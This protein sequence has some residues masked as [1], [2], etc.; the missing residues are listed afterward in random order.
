MAYINSQKVATRDECGLV[1]IGNHLDISNDGELTI[2]LRSIIEEGVWQPKLI[3][4]PEGGAIT[5]KILYANYSKIGSLV[6]AAFDLQVVQME[7]GKGKTSSHV[8]IEG[9]PLMSVS[10][11]GYCGSVNI[12]YFNN[13]NS[14]VCALSGS[15]RPE[16]YSCDIWHSRKNV[17]TLAK[18]EYGDIKISTRL[19]GI[20]IYNCA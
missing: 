7:R 2:N 15:V 13:L 14:S 5:C 6:H 12:T 18:L 4:G 19:Q 10:S 1:K 9:I 8:M 17:T 3:S 20:I 16:S 11:D